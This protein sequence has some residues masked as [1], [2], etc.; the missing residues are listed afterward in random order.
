MIETGR[1]YRMEMNVGKPEVKRISR[2]QSP[3]Q[4]IMD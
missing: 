3:T 4:N 1:C 2:Q